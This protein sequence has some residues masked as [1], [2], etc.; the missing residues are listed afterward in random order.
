MSRDRSVATID[1]IRKDVVGNDDTK[2]VEIR[3]S[4]TRPLESRAVQVHNTPPIDVFRRI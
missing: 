3:I 2:Y 4:T 1:S